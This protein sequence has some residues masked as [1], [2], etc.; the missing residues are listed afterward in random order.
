M[1]LELD[2]VEF[3]ARPL[4]LLMLIVCFHVWRAI[5]TRQFFNLSI[6]ETLRE[7]FVLA[8]STAEGEHGDSETWDSRRRLSHDVA[9]RLYDCPNRSPCLP[10]ISTWPPN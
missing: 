8:L 6:L 3:N 9:S 2:S 10:K 1:A 7:S 4:K 5:S